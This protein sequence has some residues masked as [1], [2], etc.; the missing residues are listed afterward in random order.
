MSSRKGPFLRDLERFRTELVDCRKDT[1]QA[2]VEATKPIYKLSK[3]E[4]NLKSENLSDS[5]TDIV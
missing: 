2:Y 3:L 1:L 4:K 5:K